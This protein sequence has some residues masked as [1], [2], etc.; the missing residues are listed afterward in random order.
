[1]SD[2]AD[3]MALVKLESEQRMDEQSRGHSR[4]RA[5]VAAHGLCAEPR[6][7]FGD[8]LLNSSQSSVNDDQHLHNQF[9]HVIPFIKILGSQWHTSV[10]AYAMV[11]TITEPHYLRPSRCLSSLPNVPTNLH[12]Q[13]SASVALC[14][15]TPPQWLVLRLQKQC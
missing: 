11:G 4:K 3:L 8:N 12:H 15:I 13:G 7:P 9:Q 2:N 14:R 1:M 6:T 10:C 5:D